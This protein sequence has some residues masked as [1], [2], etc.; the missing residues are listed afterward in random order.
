MKYECEYHIRPSGAR[1]P[2]NHSSSIPLRHG[3]C[4]LASEVQETLCSPCPCCAAWPS[5]REPSSPETLT[6]HAIVHAS[7]GEPSP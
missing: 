1:C 7:T 5:P 6:S 4:A 3:Y 2:G